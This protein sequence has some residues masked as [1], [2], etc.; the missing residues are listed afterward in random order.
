MSLSE[1]S[2]ML[3]FL[4]HNPCIKGYFGADHEDSVTEMQI[5]HLVRCYQCAPIRPIPS[6]L[7][8][9]LALVLHLP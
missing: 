7:P 2:P 6:F 9:P 4:W 8:L 3:P 1:L 5:G